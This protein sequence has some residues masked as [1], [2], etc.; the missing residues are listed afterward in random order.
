MLG[1]STHLAW[2]ELACRDRGRTTYPLDWRMDPTR[3]A[4]LA[5][6]FETVRAECCLE[7]AKD[8]PLT[9]L[10][11][12]R[13]QDYQAYLRS[14]PA[15]KAALKSQHCEGRA[16]DLA[17]PRGL[18][19]DQFSACVKRAASHAGSPIRYIEYRPSM[20]YIHVDVRPT[21]KLVEETV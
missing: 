17:C 15:Y 4:A 19:F 1:P 16:V 8:C 20:H 6:A 2:M 9:V 11:G 5:S 10:E 21:S 18:T 13:T 14:I 3:A 12:Y 7:L